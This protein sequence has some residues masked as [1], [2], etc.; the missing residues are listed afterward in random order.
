MD[1]YDD[2]IAEIMTEP[3]TT[4]FLSDFDDRTEALQRELFGLM[5]AN[6]Q[7]FRTLRG[8]RLRVPR[9]RMAWQRLKPTYLPNGSDSWMTSAWVR[10]SW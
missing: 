9:R 10:P 3:T 1:A 5:A 4:G 2:R 6:Y 8:E 7:I